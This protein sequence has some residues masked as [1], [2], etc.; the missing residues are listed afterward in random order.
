[1]NLIPGRQRGMTLIELMVALAI[2]SFLIA[3]A[4]TVYIQSRTTYRTNEN[5]ARMQEN[6]RFAIETMAPDIRM[7]GHWGL[8]NNGVLISGGQNLV[9]QCDG[10]DVAD[11][12][13]DVD[14]PLETNGNEYDIPCAAHDGQARTTSDVLVVRRASGSSR[15]SDGDKIQVQSTLA[16]GVLFGDGVEP[17]TAVDP[18]DAPP[19]T[20]D[21]LVHAYYIAENSSS[22]GEGVPSLRRHTLISAP[23]INAGLLEDQ[24]IIPGIEDMQ[25]Q[26]GVDTDGDG[27]IERY[28]DAGSELVNPDAGGY[29]PG[30]RVLAVR[31]WLIVRSDYPET[32][33]EDTRV[34]P[35]PDAA[36]G[37]FQAQGAARSFRRVAVSR[38][39]LLRNS[40]GRTQ[41]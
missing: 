25:I 32:G 41:G 33:F 11:W 3:G 18:G 24:E 28:V 4:V 34:Y 13:L 6:A 9:I 7:A 19:T 26:L 20:R 36:L 8:V 2:G 40:R 5:L 31:V 16:G 30:A 27:A 17:I 37:P 14:Q 1:M 38:T 35:R 23:G 15:D 21:V 39:I 29:L 22:L 10:N 12:A